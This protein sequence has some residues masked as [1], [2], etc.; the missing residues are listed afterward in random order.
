M[1]AQKA[2]SRALNP[3]DSYAVPAIATKIT[4]KRCR[5]GSRKSEQSAMKITAMMIGRITP[6]GLWRRRGND[7]VLFCLFLLGVIRCGVSMLV[8]VTT[9]D[10][11]PWGQVTTSIHSRRW[12]QG[13]F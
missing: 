2:S 10:R 3:P 9:I 4:L 12:R 1:A 6:A 8:G 7:H 11:L 5:A 13:Q